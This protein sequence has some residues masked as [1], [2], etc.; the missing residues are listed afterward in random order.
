[1]YYC[2]DN[3]NGINLT[4]GQKFTVLYDIKYALRIFWD[5]KKKKCTIYLSVR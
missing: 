5:K 3:W 2:K 4:V 1:M